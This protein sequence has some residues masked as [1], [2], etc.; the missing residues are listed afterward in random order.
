M[1]NQ[2]LFTFAFLFVCSTLTLAQD[3]DLNTYDFRY[4]KYRGL[5]LDFDLG[6]RGNQNFF[7]RQDTFARDSSFENSRRNSTLFNFNPRYFSF[8]N[9]DA[10]QRTVDASF[11]GDLNF[12]RDK[13]V[14]TDGRALNRVLDNDLSLS[15]SN[16]SRFYN[17]EKFRYFQLSTQSGFENELR[18]QELKNEETEPYNFLEKTD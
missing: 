16:T 11:Q 2:L 9:T 1:K 8:I 10:L 7:S 5:S 3:Y 15:Y 12:E 14:S 4:Q 18:K 13:I 17:G 6:N